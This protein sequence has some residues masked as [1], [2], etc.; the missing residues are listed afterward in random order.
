[1]HQGGALKSLIVLARQASPRHAAKFVID[2]RDQSLPGRS[3]TLAPAGEQI[4]DLVGRST[5]QRPLSRDG[6]T[7]FP[8]RK[9]YPA[10]RGKSMNSEH[11]IS[12]G[13]GCSAGRERPRTEA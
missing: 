5:V 8:R 7:G 6:G 11:L 9:N 12:P 13:P 4:R 2:E 1:M 3:V 10:L